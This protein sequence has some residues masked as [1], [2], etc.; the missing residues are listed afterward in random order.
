[1][2]EEQTVFQ[3]VGEQQSAAELSHEEEPELPGYKLERL[4]G[5]GS[6]G[7]VWAGVHERTGRKVAVKLLV[8]SLTSEALKVEL[9]RL[10]VATDHRRQGMAIDLAR[11]RLW[12]AQT[13]GVEQAFLQQPL[14]IRGRTAAH[15]VVQ[16][17]QA[18]IVANEF[19]GSPQ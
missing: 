6:F 18:S 11:S 10:R 9:D 15:I 12:W 16:C 1:M 7:Q 19:P 14:C 3:T 2:D 5:A 17:W 4:V 13:Q 8:S